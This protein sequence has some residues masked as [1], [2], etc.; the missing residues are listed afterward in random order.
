METRHILSVLVKNNSGVLSRISGLFSRRGYNIDSLSVGKTENPEVSR[1][2]IAVYADDDMILQIK[3]QVAKL[4]EVIKVIELTP[5][6]SVIREM[7]MI[8]IDASQDNRASIIE[9]ANIFRARIVDVALD[10]L[11]IETTG[12]QGKTDALISMLSVYGV[13]E[14]I[15]TGCTALQRGNKELKDE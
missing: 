8:K 4:V 1:M 5:Q 13:K 10:A 11:I 3:N 7:V 12:D 9:I 15:R 14:V 6:D 2:T